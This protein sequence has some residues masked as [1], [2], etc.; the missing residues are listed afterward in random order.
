[1]PAPIV[2]WKKHKR[3]LLLGL[4]IFRL[5]APPLQLGVVELYLVWGV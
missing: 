3:G 2:G 5:V 4:V 1:M